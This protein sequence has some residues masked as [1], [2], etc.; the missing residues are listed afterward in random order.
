MKC[1][2]GKDDK[3]EQADKMEDDMLLRFDLD[4]LYDLFSI[5]FH[6]QVY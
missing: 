3:E 1:D 6:H 5:M 4:T 2:D